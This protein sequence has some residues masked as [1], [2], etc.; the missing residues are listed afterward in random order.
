MNHNFSF[1]ENLVTKIHCR[2]S[3]TMSSTIV[4]IFT[5]I[6]TDPCCARSQVQTIVL[7]FL[8]FPRENYAPF[9]LSIDVSS[10]TLI[11]N[12]LAAKARYTYLVRKDL[13]FIME[14]S[15]IVNDDKINRSKSLYL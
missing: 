2:T 4:L 11:F 15:V 7:L 6:H 13:I 5:R 3:F 9:F 14:N 8:Y 10:L 1:F 12:R